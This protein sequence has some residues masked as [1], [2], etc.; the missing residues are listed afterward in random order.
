M[1][2]SHRDNLDLDLPSL[3]VNAVYLSKL[4]YK[5]KKHD[6]INYHIK[7]PVIKNACL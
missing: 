6:C 5:I 3:C 2:K 7:I 4:I 1:R